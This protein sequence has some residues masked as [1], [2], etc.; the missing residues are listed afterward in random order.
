MKGWT[1]RRL[2]DSALAVEFE[3]V[4]DPAVNARVLAIGERIRRAGYPGVRDVVEGYSSVTVDFDPLRTD[5]GLLSSALGDAAEHERGNVGD[6]RDV[7]LPVCY[8]GAFGPDLGE[9]AA[10]AGCSEEEVVALHSGSRYRVYMLGFLPG[11]AYM[12]S[13]GT[14]IASPRRDTPRLRVPAGSVGIAGRQTGV[15][16]IEA[17][18]GWRLIG[19]C[20]AKAFDPDRADPYLLHAGDM[21][22]FEP[23]NASEYARAQRAVIS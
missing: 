15:Y 5:M 6:G 18:G 7:T 20:A 23:V 2:G 3:P 9:V 11:F 8:G 17:P 22:R 21:V 12:G 1:L 16:P 19:R 4:I 14:Q 10:F 13:V